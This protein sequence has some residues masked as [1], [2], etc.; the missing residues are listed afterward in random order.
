M[1]PHREIRAVPL[2]ASQGGGVLFP[3]WFDDGTNLYLDTNLQWHRHL[4]PGGLVFP[5]KYVSIDSSGAIHSI[6]CNLANPSVNGCDGSFSLTHFLSLDGGLTWSNF[7]HLWPDATAVGNQATFEWDMQADGNLD[8]LVLSMRVQ[9]ARNNSA[10]GEGAD[11]DLIYHIRGYRDSLEVDTITQIGLGDLDAVSG[12]GNDIRFDFSSLAILPDGGVVVAY[13]D[14]TDEDPMFAIEIE[15]PEE[16][17][18][19]IF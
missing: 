12:A 3:R 5:S 16:Y 19:T 15:I 18:V 17:L 8:L 1:T 11:V 9:T 4:L 2:P 14:S 6:S 13:H 7:T 10:G